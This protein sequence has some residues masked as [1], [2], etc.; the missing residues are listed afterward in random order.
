MKTVAKMMAS[1]GMS[2]TLARALGWAM[3]RFAPHHLSCREFEDFILEYYEGGLAETQ[4][5]VFEF[6]MRMCP[7]CRT[8]LDSYARSV[9]LGRG[10]HVEEPPEDLIRT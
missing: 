8:Y 10:F 2:G 4:R 1:R 9:E 5:D 7:M 6:H 3:L